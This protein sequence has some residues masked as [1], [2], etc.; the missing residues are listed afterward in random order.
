MFFSAV[1]SLILCFPFFSFIFIIIICYFF[2]SDLNSSWGKNLFVLP[3]RSSIIS[4]G[5]NFYLD[6]NMI[7]KEI[8]YVENDDDDEIEHAHN[9]DYKTKNIYIYNHFAILIASKFPNT[10]TNC[11]IFFFLFFFLFYFQS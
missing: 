9:N 10:F 5:K 8:Q 3:D 1:F 2:S 6:I 7:T 4:C 11:I